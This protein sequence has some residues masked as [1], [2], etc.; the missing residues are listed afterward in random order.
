[1]NEQATCVVGIDVFKR[2][3]D[4]ALL[5]NSKTKSKVFD[6]TSTGHLELSQWLIERG[7]VVRR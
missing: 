3:L 6:N 7:G 4:I 2:K 1:M 5:A